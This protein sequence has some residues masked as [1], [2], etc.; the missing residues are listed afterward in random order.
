MTCHFRGC[1]AFNC[2]GFTWICNNAQNSLISSWDFS[3]EKALQNK[4]RRKQIMYSFIALYQVRTTFRHNRWSDALPHM[5]N[6]MKRSN[7]QKRDKIYSVLG[8]VGERISLQCR[9]VTSKVPKTVKNLV[10]LQFCSWDGS[11]GQGEMKMWLC[12]YFQH[13]TGYIGTDFVE[14]SRQKMQRSEEEH[15]FSRRVLWQERVHFK[16]S[17][18]TLFTAGAPAPVFFVIFH[19]I[20]HVALGDQL[21]YSF[22]PW[23]VE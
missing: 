10:V 7:L 17:E 23:A 3:R 21:Y 19:Q 18:W 9:Q 11:F 14:E 4:Q 12:L 6:R 13:I 5:S 1:L 16:W 15:L 8:C 20:L 22:E 2:S